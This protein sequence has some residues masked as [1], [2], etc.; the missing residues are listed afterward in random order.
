MHCHTRMPRLSALSNCL[1]FQRKACLSRSVALFFSKLMSY[2]VKFLLHNNEQTTQST[3]TTTYIKSFAAA[4]ALRPKT[5]FCVCV[6]VW[7]N[8]SMAEAFVGNSFNNM[9]NVC[10]VRNILIKK[11]RS[12]AHITICYCYTMCKTI[13]ASLADKNA[14]VTVSSGL[15]K[16]IFSTRQQWIAHMLKCTGISVIEM[17]RC[18]WNFGFR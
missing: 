2:P 6:C 1:P 5:L 17:V 10:C 16:K 9:T 4:P 8:F 14:P 7:H 12:T 3:D 18:M 15:V 13:R 11:A